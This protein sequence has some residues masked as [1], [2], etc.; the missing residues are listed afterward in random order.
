M[1]YAES[2]VD[3]EKE[4]LAIKGILSSMVNPLVDIMQE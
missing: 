1:T 2:G 4:E 3:I